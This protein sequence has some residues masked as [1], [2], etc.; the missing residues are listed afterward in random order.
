MKWY[1]YIYFNP[2]KADNCYGFEPFYVGKGKNNRAE[3]HL[4]ECNLKAE[5]NRHK[6]NTIRK[7]LKQKL[8]P[9]IIKAFETDVEEDAFNEEIRLIAL[10]GRADLK[11]GPLT[12]LT[13]GG[14]GK[15]NNNTLDSTRRLLSEKTS[16]AHADGR[17]KINTTAWSKAGLA[18]AHSKEGRE[19]SAISRT[20]QKRSLETKVKISNSRKR[21]IESLSEEE[22]KQKLGTMCGR[23]LSENAIAK[24]RN[25]N[26]KTLKVEIFGILYDSLNLAVKATG[27]NKPKIKRDPSFKIV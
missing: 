26:P 10:F 5:R 1:V 15:S 2:L 22:R 27:I 16:Q 3:S 6:S 11:K 13:D 19:K 9:I 8:T 18:R 17:L 20:G 21:F 24:M 25:N 14:E 4:H 12:N 7:I 23:S